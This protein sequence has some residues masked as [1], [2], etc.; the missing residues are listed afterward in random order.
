LSSLILD[1]LQRALAEPDGLPLVASKA[2]PGLFAANASGKQASQEARAAGWV[3]VVRQETRG[4]TTLEI[5]AITEKGL[6]HLLEQSSPRPVLEAILKA[7]DGCQ[8]RITT[9]IAEVERN[10]RTLDAL[11]GLAEK[12]VAQLRTPESALPPWVRNGHHH[13]SQALIIEKL[14]GWTKLGDYPLPELFDTL[15]AGSPQFHDALRALHD[16]QTIYLHPWTGPLHETPRPALGLL[17]GHEVAY[18]VSLRP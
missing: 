9:W 14:R 12:V 3:D 13:D 8:E 15:K 2:S 6:A 17:V 11:K 1:A 5:A 16:R 10:Q 7:I 18:Y 4:K